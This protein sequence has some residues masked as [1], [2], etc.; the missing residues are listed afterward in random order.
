MADPNAQSLVEKDRSDRYVFSM[1]PEKDVI[2]GHSTRKV[3]A[4]CKYMLPTFLSKA[5]EHPDL[6]VLDVGCGP[7]SITIGLAKLVPQGHVTGVDLAEILLEHARNDAKAQ[8]VTNVTF[9]KADAY[10]LP[11]PD[12]S[13]D[14]VHTHQAVL[15]LHNQVQAIRE[16]IRVLKTPGGLLCMREGI[17][18]SSLWYP[19]NSVLEEFARAFDALQASY[20]GVSDSGLKLKAWTVEAGVPREKLTFTASAW[21]FDTLEK[22]EAYGGT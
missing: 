1:K 14:V 6:K 10:N 11:F 9:T 7:G 5:Q 3:E 12:D 18:S 2:K 4:E 17:P 19:P 13:L 15:H 22:R 16:F 20:G 21:C 8:G